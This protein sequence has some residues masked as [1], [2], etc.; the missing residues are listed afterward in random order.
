MGGSI[1]GILF[2][3]VAIPVCVILLWWNEGRAITTANSLKEGAANEKK[4]VHFSGEAKT[5]SEIEDPD[6]C[7]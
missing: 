5:E 6:V 2:G 4:L 1:K 3:L 7:A